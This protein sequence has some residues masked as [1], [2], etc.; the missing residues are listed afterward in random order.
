MLLNYLPASKYSVSFF[1]WNG[2]GRYL[3]DGGASGRGIPVIG[4]KY[5]RK[6]EQEE[7]FMRREAK[8]TNR[9]HLG[10]IMGRSKVLKAAAPPRVL[11]SHGCVIFIMKKL[12]FFIISIQR[13]GR[14]FIWLTKLIK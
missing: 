5:N 9:V 1:I 3:Q 10:D 14:I 11:P 2:E 8:C 6:K 4:A 12:I 7:S 13:T